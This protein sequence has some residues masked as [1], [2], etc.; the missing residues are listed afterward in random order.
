MLKIIVS[1][2]MIGG[3]NAMSS[4]AGDRKRKKRKEKERKR[5]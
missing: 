5:E 4:V 3:K 2:A 1:R